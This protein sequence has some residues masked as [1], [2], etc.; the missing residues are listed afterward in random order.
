M[1]SGYDHS[2]AV[3]HFTLRLRVGVRVKDNGLRYPG[4]VPL[5]L[6]L[7]PDKGKPT[8]NKICYHT[9]N[10]AFAWSSF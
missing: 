7:I 10:V 1:E 4:V 6:P 3:P 8:V 5:P 9:Y 2:E